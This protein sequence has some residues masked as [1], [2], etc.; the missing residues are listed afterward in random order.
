MEKKIRTIFE[1]LLKERYID[2]NKCGLWILEGDSRNSFVGISEEEPIEYQLFY[3]HNRDDVLEEDELKILLHEISHIIV[4]EDFIKNKGTTK[5]REELE[6]YEEGKEII[7][8]MD[9]GNKQE[10]YKKLFF[11]NEANI[12]GEKLYKMMKEE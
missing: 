2:K 5:L 6:R 7:N 8:L 11:E 4:F 10:E 9:S 3:Y 12:M 1:K